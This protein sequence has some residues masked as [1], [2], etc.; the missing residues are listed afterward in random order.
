[1]T[2]LTEEKS[3]IYYDVALLHI[4]TI[5]TG[6]LPSLGPQFLSLMY[7][8]IDEADFSTLI[9]KY[10]DQT[11]TGFVSG[12]LGDSSLYK[13]MLLYPFSLFLSLMPTLL[14]LTKI[15]KIINI[16]QH[17]SSKER[18]NFPSA[19][20]LTICV[21]KD[22]RRQGIAESLYGELSL[23]FQQKERSKFTIVVGQSL[24]ANKFYK[25]QGAYIADEIQVHSGVNSNIYIQNI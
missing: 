17:V 13:K 21:N 1:M 9:V 4:E 23:F 7:R 3:K 11:L 24:N 2:T 25:K 5:K 10:D 8:C 12:S 20:L 18:N 14:D 22:Y 15:K 19:E 6:F 16:L